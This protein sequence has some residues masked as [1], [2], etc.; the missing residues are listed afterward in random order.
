M[1]QLMQVQVPRKINIYKYKYGPYDCPYV[2]IYFSWNLLLQAWVKNVGI[3]DERMFPGK[4]MLLVM[5]W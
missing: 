3:P 2:N 4:G 5:I 1:V